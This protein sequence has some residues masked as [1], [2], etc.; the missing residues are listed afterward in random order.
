MAEDGSCAGLK[1]EHRNHALL[2]PKFSQSEVVAE[3][4]A[5]CPYVET[6]HFDT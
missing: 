2:S 4:W 3:I 1:P 6:D 5:I